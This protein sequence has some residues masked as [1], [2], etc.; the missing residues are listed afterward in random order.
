[1]SY[2]LPRYTLFSPGEKVQIQDTE[3]T[4][5]PTSHSDNLWT[6]QYSDQTQT[7]SFQDS[8][9]VEDSFLFDTNDWNLRWSTHPDYVFLYRIRIREDPDAPDELPI[10][11]FWNEERREYLRRRVDGTLEVVD[12][13]NEQ[14][15][16]N[17][18]EF[19]WMFQNEKLKTGTAISHA[20]GTSFSNISLYT[21]KLSANRVSVPHMDVSY[22]NTQDSLHISN[23]D[24]QSIQIDHLDVQTLGTIRAPVT[25]R[26][27]AR[28][29]IENPT[30]TDDPFIGIT[31]EGDWEYRSEEHVWIL[32]NPLSKNRWTITTAN[33]GSSYP[34][35]QFRRLDT[36]PGYFLVR[37]DANR[38]LFL[39]HSLGWDDKTEEQAEP[40]FEASRLDL[41]WLISSKSRPT[42]SQ[43]YARGLT[44]DM[45]RASEVD[46]S[47]QIQIRHATLSDREITPPNT[48]HNLLSSVETDAYGHITNLIPYAIADS[49]SSLAQR[50]SVLQYEQRGWDAFGDATDLELFQDWIGVTEDQFGESWWTRSVMRDSI[51]ESETLQFVW[52]NKKKC[53]GALTTPE[54][55]VFFVPHISDRG[56]LFDPNTYTVQD[57][58]LGSNSGD[59]AGGVLLNNGKIAC[60]PYNKDEMWFIRS[61]AWTPEDSEQD[62][63]PIPNE[64]QAGTGAF[65]GGARMI[66]G[67]IVCSPYNSDRVSIYDTRANTWD[68]YPIPD[69]ID[70]DSERYRD[71]IACPDGQVVCIPY[72]SK[73]FLHVLE[74]TIF[75][76]RLGTESEDGLFLPKSESFAMYEPGAFGIVADRD[77]RQSDMTLV[78]DA[79]FPRLDEIDHDMCLFNAG[80]TLRSIWI[81]V[82]LF[83]GFAEFYARAG[84]SSAPPNN[85]ATILRFPNASFLDGKVHR[86]L[87]DI[88]T[89]PGQMRVFVDDLLQGQRNINVPLAFARDNPPQWAGP[90]SNNMFGG[91]YKEEKVVTPLDENEHPMS[92]EHWYGFP[93]SI[94]S[95]VRLYAGVQETN[96]ER[97]SRLAIENWSRSWKQPVDTPKLVGYDTMDSVPDSLEPPYG[98]LQREW[99]NPLDGKPYPISIET[100]TLPRTP[101]ARSDGQ[102][103]DTTHPQWFNWN[104]LTNDPMQWEYTA[105]SQLSNDFQGYHAFR[106]T[107]TPW[108]S[109]NI[110]EPQSLFLKASRALRP[111]G[112]TIRSWY[113][114]SE[115]TLNY[116]PLEWKLYGIKDETQTELDHVQQASLGNSEDSTARTDTFIIPSTYETFDRYELQ[117]LSAFPST[118]PRVVVE[119]WDMIFFP[120]EIDGYPVWNV[121]NKNKT[122]VLSGWRV[123]GNNVQ[124]ADFVLRFHEPRRVHSIEITSG[125]FTGDNDELGIRTV[126]FQGKNRDDISWVQLARFE[127]SWST[128]NQTVVRTLE[129]PSSPYDMF[130]MIVTESDSQEYIS[131]QELNIRTTNALPDETMFD[132]TNP[133]AIETGGTHD[134][135]E[136]G[137]WGGA[138][139]SRGIVCAPYEAEHIGLYDI[140]TR[141]F[142]KGPKIGQFKYA[143]A[144]TLSNG[145]VALIPYSTDASLLIY[146][147]SADQIIEELSISSEINEMFAGAALTYD[148]KLVLTPYNAESI[149]VMDT[150]V[151]PHPSLVTHPSLNG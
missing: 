112:Y 69:S 130:R 92:S 14:E 40:G 7:W 131:V 84:D 82:R 151:V 133:F 124:G 37:E 35:I 118:A 149:R 15:E 128:A 63:V 42:P 120:D 100:T 26:S 52:T 142:S 95:L 57:I 73:T 126:V 12:R 18:N 88:Q 79:R 56:L 39:N 4:P 110:N 36:F 89:D 58:D 5:L 98:E 51:P 123:W 8:N 72:R 109:A 60:I 70:A 16:P 148:G 90:N 114:A 6:V 50:S 140:N 113:N 43:W 11:Y 23:V 106:D 104:S 116:P 66:G 117:I 105:T 119:Q 24:A 135:T 2:L 138:F 1:M 49:D 38:Q 102:G 53:V 86:L 27:R 29:V 32:S 71:A 97:I 55:F 87:V 34:N 96:T 136:P 67:E 146:D 48:S 108:Q 41:H 111:Y 47:G 76:E 74:N 75:V 94:R 93:Y 107:V 122:D 143:G 81:G 44:G 22:W 28:I 132:N 85:A 134:A 144:R 141:T 9:E 83:G 62:R 25:F 65:F 127:D 137:Y 139:S 20:Y 145:M 46:M 150:G 103:A 21:N 30:R 13:T 3:G 10:G 68:I 33:A 91:V 54:G 17:L 80:G 99:T 64:I 129:E 101:R 77:E 125:P 31:D 59:F 78:M 61:P 121:M 19:G 147:P 115:P 45:V